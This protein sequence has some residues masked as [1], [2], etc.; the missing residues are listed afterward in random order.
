MQYSLTTDLTNEDQ[1]QILFIF[2][3]ICTFFSPSWKLLTNNLTAL[4]I[5]STFVLAEHC[6]L[7]NTESM[8]ESW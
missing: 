3:S 2:Y 7:H 5:L 1:M 4:I 8:T 6:L